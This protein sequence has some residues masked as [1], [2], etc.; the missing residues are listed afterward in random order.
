MT[1]L[2]ILDNEDVE[3]AALVDLDTFTPLLVAAAGPQRKVILQAFMDTTPFDLTALSAE[4]IRAAFQSF[5]SGLADTAAEVP[6]D[7]QDPVV[8]SGGQ[9][10]DDLAA[11]A[12]A[13]SLDPGSP[14]DPAPA[15]SIEPE[16]SPVAMVKVQCWNCNG[17][18]SLTVGGDEPAVQCNMCSGHGWVERPAMPAA[19][20]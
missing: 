17:T 8:T 13:G 4:S 10:T 18:G 14:P 12:L 9:I 1:E 6:A 5:L 19:Q 15:P 7:V 3:L 20:Q 11:D 16:P 2:V